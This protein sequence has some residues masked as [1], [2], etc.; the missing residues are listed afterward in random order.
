[1]L[2]AFYDNPNCRVTGGM[3]ASRY[4]FDYCLTLPLYHDMTTDEQNYIV[5]QLLEALE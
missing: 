1:M 5:N 2:K 3:T 4:A